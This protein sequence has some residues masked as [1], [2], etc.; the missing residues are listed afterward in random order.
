M[1]REAI[2]K[3]SKGNVYIVSTYATMGEGGWPLRTLGCKRG[4]AGFGPCVHTHF[5]DQIR[6]QIDQKLG[7]LVRYVPKLWVAHLGSA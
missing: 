7:A 3:L 5:T 4:Y 1:W 2:E 6:G